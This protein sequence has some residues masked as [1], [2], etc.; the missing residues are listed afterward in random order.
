MNRTPA[1]RVVATPGDTDLDAA[2]AAAADLD[3]FKERQHLCE[4]RFFG[5]ELKLASGAKDDAERLFRL[6]AAACPKA[7]LHWGATN[8]ELRALRAAP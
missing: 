3:P 8:E 6:A 2:L 7:E 5:A 1:V 4:A